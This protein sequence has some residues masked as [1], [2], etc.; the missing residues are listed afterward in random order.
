MG[1]EKCLQL[2]KQ[3][4]LNYFLYFC[5]RF[6]QS[7][8]LIQTMTSKRYNLEDESAMVSLPDPDSI[9]LW[10][11]ESDRGIVQLK[12][13]PYCMGSLNQTHFFR[14]TVGPDR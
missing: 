8:W 9:F 1:N 2:I 3:L 13:E 11:I 7:L 14:H 5:D 10:S 6:P 4:L 12:I